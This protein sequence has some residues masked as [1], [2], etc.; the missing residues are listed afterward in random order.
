[1]NL[2]FVAKA[3]DTVMALREVA[4]RVGVG[5]APRS[6]DLTLTDSTSTG[7]EM[8]LA[9]VVVAALKEAYD[10][11]HARLELE[12]AQLEEQRRRAEEAMRLELRR[13][14]VDR[15]IAR[16]RM[17]AGAA[18]VG[19]MVSAAL[20]AVR[21]DLAS[22]VSRGLL[23]AG[24]LLLIAALASALKAQE[25]ING[26]RP[27]AAGSPAPGLPG[28]AALWLLTSGIAL[29]AVALLLPPV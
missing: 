10:R 3:F 14:S 8:R 1:M 18:L 15:E 21:S 9:K 4:R 17:L 6:G 27:D 22:S 16:L 28:R 24:W 5:G 26:E 2:G 25:R 13:Q 7:L 29:A 20:F 19:W 11:D 12:R 23:A